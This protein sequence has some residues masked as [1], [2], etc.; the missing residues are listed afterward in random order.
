MMSL[1]R[2]RSAVWSGVPTSCGTRGVFLQYC[3]PTTQLPAQPHATAP[4]PADNEVRW[5]SSTVKFPMPKADDD[6]LAAYKAAVRRMRDQRDKAE[7]EIEALQSSQITETMRRWEAVQEKAALQRELNGM[8]AAI[9]NA[10]DAHRTESIKAQHQIAV[11]KRLREQSET[12]TLRE[13]CSRQE[14]ERLAEARLTLLRAGFVTACCAFAFLCLHRTKEPERSASGIGCTV[15]RDCVDGSLDEARRA[16]TELEDKLG[17]ANAATAR[18]DHRANGLQHSLALVRRTV[19]GL[20]DELDPGCV[21]PAAH[22][23]CSPATTTTW[24]AKLRCWMLY[25]STMA[26]AFMMCAAFHKN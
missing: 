22:E 6:E 18:E 9:K 17:A 7:L 2:Y 12:M 23:T 1:L 25:V 19:A 14:A 13:Q 21:S 26:L 16:I 5:P 20:L 24:A 8:Q 4:L 15:D 10:A 3:Q 11:L